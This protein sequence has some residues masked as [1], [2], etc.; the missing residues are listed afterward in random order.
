MKL[1]IELED[2]K[3]YKS[4]DKIGVVC[5]GCNKSY[6]LPKNRVLVG[7]KNNKNN[8][9]SNKCQSSFNKK[10]INLSCKKCG[11]IF[12]KKLRYHKKNIKKSKTGNFYCSK[13]CA[14]TDIKKSS[15]QKNELSIKLKQIYVDKLIKQGYKAEDFIMYKGKLRCKSKKCI[16]KVCDKEFNW[17]IFK[18]TCSQSCLNIINRKS[19]ILA[20]KLSSSKSY[21]IKSRSKNERLMYKKIKD[22]YSDALHNYRA[23]DGWDADIVIP[24]LKIAIHWNGVWHYKNVY[25]NEYGEK[26]FESVK[27]KDILKYKAIE[28]KGYTNYII[29]DMG[30]FNINKVN[31]EFDVFL[32]KVNP[33]HISTVGI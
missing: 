31:Y 17:V 18:K 25:N 28:E 9:C 27:A 10:T 5:V 21:Q 32:K 8:Y 20:G 14:S 22:V 12:T 30:R 2:L 7:L 19:S 11:I 3:K 29:V 1:L 24:S 4:K 23:F 13:K 33:N 6:S 15:R 16:C 26:L